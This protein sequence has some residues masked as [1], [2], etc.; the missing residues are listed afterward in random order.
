M[1]RLIVALALA[2]L[3]S[4]PRAASANGA[5]LPAEVVLQAYVKQEEKRALLL[6]RVPLDLLASF[7]LPKRGPGYLDLARIDE[8]LQAV[9]A[10][11]ARQ[12]ELRANGAQLAPVTRHARISL[13]S[14]PS[15]RD[16]D[17]ARAHLEG[18]RLPP[19]T[20][21]FWNQ[22]FFDTMLE[23][24]L[25]EAPA[26]LSIRVNVAPELGQRLRLELEFLPLGIAPHRFALTGGSGW[27]ALEPR[28]YE[29]A[30]QF[31]WTGVAAG[32][33]L[34]RLITLLCLVAPFRR[35]RSALLLAAA[36]VILQSLALTAAPVAGLAAMRGVAALFEG[37]LPAVV[38]LLAIGNLAA[39]SLRWRF[40]ASALLGAL[41]GLALV[42]T[43][44][45][46]WQFSG[47]HPFIAAL[48]FN[49]GVALAQFG[50]AALAWA[51]LR[52]VVDRVLGA[53]LDVVVAS[54]VAGHLGWHWMFERGH[55]LGHTL[56]HA[57]RSE[58]I[59]IALYLLAA[60]L[61]AVACRRLPRS[62]FDDPRIPSLLSAL[63]RD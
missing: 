29:A 60:V 45:T 8:R 10:A 30:A 9:A 38:F 57:R 27:I 47:T 21:L 22:G 63:K 19:D 28:W 48:S 42:P 26:R 51:V 61:V 3:L 13:L 58:I 5:D 62:F 39:P 4:A 6:F 52:C 16:Y 55:E 33:T 46:A 20:D 24:P 15:F 37:V 40:L 49:I 17:A 25:G 36:W 43:L 12:I 35:L 59:G 34:E 41:G 23:F 11:S 50:G 54:A 53:P 56:E 31:A 32:A 1:I 44:N 18:P 7:G 14:D 2:A